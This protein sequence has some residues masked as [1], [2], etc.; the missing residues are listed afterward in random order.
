MI[1]RPER[2]P[3]G[4]RGVFA[5]LTLVMW[6][7]YAWLLLPL[8]TSLLW[9]AGLTTAYSATVR[10]VG[11]IDIVLVGGLVVASVAMA[12]LL[13]VWAELQ[14]HRFTGV[15]RR[16]RAPDTPVTEIASTLGVDAE[17]LRGLRNGR[18]VL[19]TMRD[20]GTPAAGTVLVALTDGPATAPAGTVT[21]A[22][23]A[24]DPAILARVP[25]PRSGGRV[26]G[27]SA[28]RHRAEE[29][30]HAPDR[31]TDDELP[32]KAAGTSTQTADRPVR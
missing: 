29:P 21:P 6:S 11:S 23:A 25:G 30:G 31:V 18:V 27:R 10:E 5:M 7:L 16:R 20:D 2:V 12:V 8:L 19:L 9:L 32:E 1:R 13:L 28:P 15:E 4:R 14:R 17:V 22:R 3:K 26:G 24:V